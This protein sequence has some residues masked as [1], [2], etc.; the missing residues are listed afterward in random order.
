MRL[1]LQAL[2][3]FALTGLAHCWTCILL[4]CLLVYPSL[5]LCCF[6]STLL[7]FAGKPSAEQLAHIR[8]RKPAP[9]VM[10]VELA[11]GSK[12]PLWNTF[13]DQQVC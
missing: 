2:A 10:E 13:K 8:T 12:V 3:G 9:P 4:C 5:L 11:D 7:R 6:C 1:M